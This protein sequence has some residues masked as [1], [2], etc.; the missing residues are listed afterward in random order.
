MSTS[1]NL[2]LTTWLGGWLTPQF[3][4]TAL[5][6]VV[7]A[8]LLPV[9]KSAAWGDDKGDN[10]EKADRGAVRLLKTIPVPGTL[11][12]PTGGKLYSFDISWVDQRSRTYYLPDRSNL[13]GYVV[14]TKTGKFVAQL[15]AGV[16]GAP[17]R[18]PPPRPPGAPTPGPR[19]LPSPA[20]RRPDPSP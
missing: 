8:V 19:P 14:D 13:P 10:E 20:P 12:N 11:N 15:Q 6:V 5:A 3:L 4:S 1:K 2:K 16:A 17:P 9:G 18:A 7:T